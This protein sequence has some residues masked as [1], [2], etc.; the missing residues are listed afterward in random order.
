MRATA[1]VFKYNVSLEEKNAHAGIEFRITEAIALE[2]LAAEVRAAGHLKEGEPIA[3]AS[4]D[5]FSDGGTR[6]TEPV[7]FY[8]EN[9]SVLALS[10]RGCEQCQ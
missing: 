10:L 7:G 8:S 3:G 1:K 4:A 9:G 6:L 5:S 2:E